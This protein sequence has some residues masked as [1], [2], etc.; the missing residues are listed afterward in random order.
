[1]EFEFFYLF[2]AGVIALT[3]LLF[4]LLG[5][6]QLVSRR[7][8]LTWKSLLREAWFEVLGKRQASGRGNGLYFALFGLF[9]IL[10]CAFASIMM[11][12]TQRIFSSPEV[13]SAPGVVHEP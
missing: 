10:F 1:M 9:M 7:F 12:L 5:V 8:G 4:L 11:L 6:R 3:G 2:A 13:P